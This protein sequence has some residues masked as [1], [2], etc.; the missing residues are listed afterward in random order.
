MLLTVPMLLT[1]LIL[2][3]VPILLPVLVMVL[4]VPV[5]VLKSLILGC[6]QFSVT[7]DQF[8]TLTAFL[9]LGEK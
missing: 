1:V 5:P 3:A 8:H 6:Q 7:M 4:L 2:L 9:L